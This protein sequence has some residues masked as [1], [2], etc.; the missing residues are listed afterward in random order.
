MYMN[1]SLVHWLFLPFPPAWRW[2]GPRHYR[3]IPILRASGRQDD[4]RTWAIK[5]LERY[6]CYG[7]RKGHFM[8]HF[9]NLWVIQWSP[10]LCKLTKIKVCPHQIYAWSST[11]KDSWCPVTY[12]L[13]NKFVTSPIQIFP[14][15]CLNHTSHT[16]VR[17]RLQGGA[18]N[19]AEKCWSMLVS[20][21]S[22]NKRNNI[23]SE[24][25]WNLSAGG[26]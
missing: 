5:G 14:R 21:S 9:Y 17:R 22:P 25:L 4:G 20:I 24:T 7:Q 23:L 6:I 8:R 19:P 18:F 12:T 16:C 10:T 2:T 1:I 3:L 15:W 11:F 26:S 13:S